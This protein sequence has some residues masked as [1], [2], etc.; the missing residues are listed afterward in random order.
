MTNS[1][2]AILAIGMSVA[3]IGY[4]IA[5]GTT[6]LS[7]ANVDGCVFYASAFTLS[8]GQRTGFLCDSNGRL[9]VTTTP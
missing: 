7:P 6:R 2:A 4:V 5:Q 8:D 1:Q 9:K 3:S